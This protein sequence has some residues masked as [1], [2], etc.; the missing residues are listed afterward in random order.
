L[1]LLSLESSQVAQDGWQVTG[2]Q[3][4][5]AS[6]LWLMPHIQA[7]FNNT[8]PVLQDV[9]VVSDPRQVLQPVEHGFTSPP[10]LLKYDPIGGEQIFDSRWA[11][12][13]QLIQLLLPGPLQVKQFGW[14]S[15]QVSVLSS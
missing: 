15:L 5:L 14:H 8:S 2:M 13:K 4:L 7:A 9:Q 3:T 1:Q 11:P 10:S 12:D 6:L